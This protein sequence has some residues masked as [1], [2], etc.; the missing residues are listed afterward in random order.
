MFSIG[1]GDTAHCF[2]RS[3]GPRRLKT[4]LGPSAYFLTMR[5]ISTSVWIIFVAGIPA[6][7]T[8]FSWVSGAY[9]NGSIAITAFALSLLV[10]VVGAVLCP[11]EPLAILMVLPIYAWLPWLVAKDYEICPQCKRWDAHTTTLSATK[12]TDTPHTYM[13]YRVKCELCG[14]EWSYRTGW[15]PYE[16]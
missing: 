13:R 2:L 12:E 7:I 9:R 5:Q 15:P 3:C 4:T 1:R 10:A 16:E 14:H 11:C 8:F 6:A